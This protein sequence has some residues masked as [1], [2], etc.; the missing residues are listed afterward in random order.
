[1]SGSTTPR[2]DP[3]A[4]LGALRAGQPRRDIRRMAM[5]GLA[6]GVGLAAFGAVVVRA[7]D[8]AG[9]LAFIREQGRSVAAKTAQVTA[10]RNYYPSSWFRSAERAPERSA[11][12]RDR[13]ADP[14][15]ADRAARDRSGGLATAFTSA[16]TLPPTVRLPSQA[17]PD[18]RFLPMTVSPRAMRPSGAGISRGSAVAYCVRTCDGYFFPLGPSTGSAA[19]DAAA[20]SSLCPA[21]ETRLFSRRIGDEMDE[22]R[23]RATGRRYSALPAAFQHRNVYNAACSCTGEGVGLATNF[24]VTR[25]P[26]LRIGDAVMTSTG[27]KVFHGGPMPYRSASFTPVRSSSLVDGKTRETLRRMEQASLPGR[28]GIAPQPLAAR[29]ATD[30]VSGAAGSL[31]DATAF[32]RPVG[33]SVAAVR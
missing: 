11:A 15:L 24:P 17:T 27:M 26:T 12:R 28:S 32:F 20:C 23:D 16:E 14:R 33:M 13:H 29:P 1:M 6:A 19:G 9:V 10:P 4:L 30:T 8:D 3:R 5:T 31:V 21:A 7:N 2:V 25:D 22:G 18:Q